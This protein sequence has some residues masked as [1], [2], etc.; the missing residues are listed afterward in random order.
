MFKGIV[1][2]VTNIL[3]LFYKIEVRG[4]EN[5]PNGP[6]VLASNHISNWDPVFL[7]KKLIN[8]FFW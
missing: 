3:Y 6:F 5:L 2:F 8:V 1:L 4:K 7:Y